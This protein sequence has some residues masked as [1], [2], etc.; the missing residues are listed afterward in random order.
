MQI[1]YCNVG[2]PSI[3]RSLH[4]VTIQLFWAKVKFAICD[5]LVILDK[6]ETQ[7]LFSADS[8]ERAFQILSQIPGNVTGA[9]N[10]SQVR[11][12]LDEE[13]GWGLEIS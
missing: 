5:L 4:Y 6:S 1:L 3:L 13:T 2:N 10:H 7:G 11:Y 12:Y 8:I 9:Y